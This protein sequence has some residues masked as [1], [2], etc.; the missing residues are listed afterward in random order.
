MTDIERISSSIEKSLGILTDIGN[1]FGRFT[2]SDGI[3]WDLKQA[4]TMWPALI[5]FLPFHKGDR[6]ALSKNHPCQ[7]NWEY[8]KHF[9]V[10]GAEGV[11]RSIGFYDDRGFYADVVFD[12]E[13]WIDDKG[14]VQPVSRKHA[15][16]MEFEYLTNLSKGGQS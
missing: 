9:L 11:I 2:T 15:Y 3:G 5:K 8:S 14:K 1:H 6:I 12:K 13:S 7:G 10:K 16:C 4:K